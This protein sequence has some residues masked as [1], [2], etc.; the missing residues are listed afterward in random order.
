MN[1]FIV[2]IVK[3][4]DNGQAHYANFPVY[5]TILK[6]LFFLFVC[7]FKPYYAFSTA[8]IMLT[9]CSKNSFYIKK[10]MTVRI[11]LC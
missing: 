5:Y 2:V 7:F 6:L 10:N 3:V 4:R 9:L 8:P 11:E 1:V